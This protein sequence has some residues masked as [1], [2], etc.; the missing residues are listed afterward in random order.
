MHVR[1][2]FAALNVGGLLV[3]SIPAAA[4]AIQA[5][6]AGSQAITYSGLKGVKVTDNAADNKRADADFKRGSST[7]KT[8]TV[9]ATKGKGSVA[10][11]GESSTLVKQLRACV[12]NNNPLD[13]NACSGWEY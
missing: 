12:R 7:A 6:T 2:R 10:Y 9:S 4:Y 5:S 3:A 11:S 1:N 8:E 13:Q